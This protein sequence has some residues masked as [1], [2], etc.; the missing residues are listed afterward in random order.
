MV[1]SAKEG[2]GNV[3]RNSITF[4]RLF[5]LSNPKRLSLLITYKCD[6][7]HTKRQPLFPSPLPLI[8]VSK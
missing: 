1:V 2:E 4:H 5:I 3:K 7:L 6:S 8:N